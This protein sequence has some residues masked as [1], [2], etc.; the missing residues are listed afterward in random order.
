MPTHQKERRLH[1][2]RTPA[3]R[4]QDLQLGKVHGDIIDV[5]RVAVFVARPGNTTFPCETSQ[6]RHSL[7]PL[8]K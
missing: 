8:G 3:M 2:Q 4:Q 5:D 1:P 7:Q 6:E